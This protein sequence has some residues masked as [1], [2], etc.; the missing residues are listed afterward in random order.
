MVPDVLDPA[1]NTEFGSYI[2]LREL[3]DVLVSVDVAHIRSFLSGDKQ[4]R[5][6][7]K[8]S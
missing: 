7:L 4:K 3:V 8:L 2:L 1:A 5:P 6:E